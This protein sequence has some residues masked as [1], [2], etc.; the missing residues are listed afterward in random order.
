MHSGNIPRLLQ[1]TNLEGYS[2][3]RLPL[4]QDTVTSMNED[5]FA[6]QLSS[7]IQFAFLRPSNN[8]YAEDIRLRREMCGLTREMLA[9]RAGVDRLT[10]TWLENKLLIP[11]E[12]SM[13]V[14]HKIDQAF[15]DVAR[16]V[17][18]GTDTVS[19]GGQVVT[20]VLN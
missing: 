17:C 14:I 8:D 13:E 16:S 18:S 5:T 20:L 10:I 6:S 1:L 11:G 4:T 2:E 3:E 15:N 19:V 7:R 9:E 12:L